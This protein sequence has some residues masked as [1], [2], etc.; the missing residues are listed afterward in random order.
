[1]KNKTKHKKSRSDDR[2]FCFW[3][4]GPLCLHPKK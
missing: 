3:A 2:D 4:F 1:M